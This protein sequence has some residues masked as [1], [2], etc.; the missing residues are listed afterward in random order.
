M[1]RF[2]ALLALVL[3]PLAAV[4]QTP[5]ASQGQGR[6]TIAP[7][8]DEDETG[9]RVIEFPNGYAR[10]RVDESDAEEPEGGVTLMPAGQTGTPE[11]A[12]SEEEEQR[13]PE[14]VS[15]AGPAPEES[16]IPPALPSPREDDAARRGTGQ[17]SAPAVPTG[18]RHD[19]CFWPEAFLAQRL[20]ELRGVELDPPVA[21][22]VLSQ[23]PT[24]TTGNLS[25]NLF[26]RA[27]PVGDAFLMTAISSDTPTLQRATELARCL[28]D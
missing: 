19:A 7:P 27:L 25:L 1:T 22:L 28:M 14:S 12:S 17:Q 5:R 4:A 13:P 3:L 11:P 6:G 23:Q 9:W 18:P 8:P 15:P 2:V 16:P 21:L 10:Y 20:M 24:L 26:G